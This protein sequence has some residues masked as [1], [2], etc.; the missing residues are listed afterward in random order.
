M[1]FEEESKASHQ[2]ISNVHGSEPESK[3][4]PEAQAGEPSLEKNDDMDLDEAPPPEPVSGLER[5]SEPEAQAG[6]PSLE[7]DNAMDLDETP[8]KPM[9][10][11]ERGSEPEAKSDITPKEVDI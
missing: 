8:A 4:E 5:G 3:A 7:E 6:E 10:G 2:P 9:S 1:L 11:L